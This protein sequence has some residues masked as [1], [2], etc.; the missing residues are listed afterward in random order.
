VHYVLM[1]ITCPLYIRFE[2]MSNNW[3]VEEVNYEFGIESFLR[4]Y[5]D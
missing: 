2:L 1:L 5:L 3:K 4:L